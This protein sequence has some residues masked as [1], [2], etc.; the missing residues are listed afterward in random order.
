MKVSPWN[1]FRGFRGFRFIGES[2]G[3]SDPSVASHR[4][5]TR[6]GEAPLQARAS[7]SRDW[8]VVMDSRSRAVLYKQ[9]V[10]APSPVSE[11]QAFLGHCR[12]LAG[13]LPDSISMALTL[14]RSDPAA[15]GV[16][17]VRG[18]PLDAIPSPP[19]EASPTA[20]TERVVTEAVLGALASVLGGSITAEGRQTSV[21]VEDLFLSGAGD[22]AAGEGN[23]DPGCLRT[24]S[25]NL[26]TP[27]PFLL[28]LR[29]DADEHRALSACVADA[30][31]A[32]PLMSGADTA[33]LRQPLFRI[34]EDCKDQWT[35]K[36]RVWS[37]PMPL[38]REGRDGLEARLGGASIMA[39]SPEAEAAQRTFRA[40]LT[41]VS[42]HVRL[43][44]GDVLVINNRKAAHGPLVPVG[45]RGGASQCWVRRRRVC[46]AQNTRGG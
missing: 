39:V 21:A 28:F 8:E 6:H 45:G 34:A 16:L 15:P 23:G 13:Y 19:T 20:A 4:T 26:E 14:F 7:L 43:F 5:M 11:P 10:G 40:A 36:R 30:K 27:P 33:L 41:A 18:G 44:P 25:P 32:I 29:A 42:R 3:W 22:P 46:A 35:G 12:N 1:Y 2:W 9:A 17:L 31:D 24:E 37:A 38:L